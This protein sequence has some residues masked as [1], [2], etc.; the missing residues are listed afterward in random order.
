MKAEHERSNH[1]V[2][3]GGADR[4]CDDF[5]GRAI[6]SREIAEL[7]FLRHPGL[8]ELRFLVRREDSGLA[9]GRRDDGAAAIEETIKACV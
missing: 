6:V 8:R 9:R 1:L 5:L 2:V 3:F 7:H 4:E